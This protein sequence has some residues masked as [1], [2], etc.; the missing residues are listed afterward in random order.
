MERQLPVT[1]D[2]GGW[3]FLATAFLTLLTRTALEKRAVWGRLTIPEQALGSDIVA[4]TT[5]DLVLPGD[6][7]GRPQRC[8]VGAQVVGSVWH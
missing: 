2:T 4:C 1:V 6:Q 5:C 8:T 7:T 3:C